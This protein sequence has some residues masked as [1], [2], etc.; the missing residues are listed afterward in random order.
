MSKRWPL[1]HGLLDEWG[2]RS[3]L[4]R[5]PTEIGE[6]HPSGEDEQRPLYVADDYFN[7]MDCEAIERVRDSG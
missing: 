4:R 3:P 6:T 5:T 2:K 7:R 1:P